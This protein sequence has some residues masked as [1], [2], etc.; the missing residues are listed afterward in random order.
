MPLRER[1]LVMVLVFAGFFTYSAVRC[2]PPGVN[3]PHYLAKAKHFWNPD[4]CRGDLFLES[5][6]AHFVFYQ[7]VGLLT[8]AFTLEQTAWIGR[9]LALALLAVGWTELFSR[10][11]PGRWSSLWAA[12]L[13]LLLQTLGNLSGEWVVGGVEAKVFAYGLVLWGL[14]FLLDRRWNRAA[15]CAGLAISV[16]PVVGIWSLVA[17]AWAGASG[18]NVKPRPLVAP[19]S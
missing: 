19:H 9:A 10:L 15:L 14:A 7:T 6:D 12:W 16:H 11:V 2:P 13:F 4:W 3:E 17:A 5:A 1:W 8:R 18:Q